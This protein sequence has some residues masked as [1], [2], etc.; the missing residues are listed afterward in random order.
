MTRHLRQRFGD[1]GEA[2]AARHLEAAGYRIVERQFRSPRG[3]VDLIAEKD[4]LLVFVEVRTRGTSAFGSP[5]ETVSASKQRKVIAAARDYLARRQGPARDVRFDVVSIVD[6]PQG[7]RL[8]HL[9]GAF[10]AS[11]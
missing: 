6:H 1:A 10:D 8:E 5:A 7:P 3:E 2:A 9:P 11:R 4:G